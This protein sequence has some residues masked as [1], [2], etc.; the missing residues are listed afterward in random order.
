MSR[1]E[2]IEAAIRDL[3]PDEFR[4]ISQCVHEIE[5]AQWDQQMDLDSAAGKLDH[6]FEE[7]EA[8]FNTGSRR[9]WPKRQ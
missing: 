3:P 4:R 2:E 5:Q 9:L 7:A 1:V 8:E 6:L